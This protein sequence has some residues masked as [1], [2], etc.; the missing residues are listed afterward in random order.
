MSPEQALAQRVVVDH[1]TDV[2]SLGATLYELLALEPAFNGRDRRELLRQIAFEEP[3]RPRR[4]NRSIPRELEVIVLKAMERNPADRYATAQALADDLRRFLEDKPIRARP[5]TPWQRLWKWGRRHQAVVAAAFLVLLAA[6]GALAASSYFFWH[7]HGLTQH[8]LGKANAQRDR[9][10]KRLELTINALDRMSITVGPREA[11]RDPEMEKVRNALLDGARRAL[12][13][14]LPDDGPDQLAREEAGRLYLAIG[15]VYRRQREFARAEEAYG[16]T[17]AVYASL[18]TEFPDFV[19]Y[20]QYLDVSRKNLDQVRASS[21]IAAGQTP[22]GFPGPSGDQR[23]LGRRY[24]ELGDQLRKEPRATIGGVDERVFQNMPWFPI[25]GD[26]PGCRGWPWEAAAAYRQA[27]AVRRKLAAGSPRAKDHRDLLASCLALANLM[28]QLREKHEQATVLE[29]AAAVADQLAVEF[30]DAPLEWKWGP[31][32]EGTEEMTI[33]PPDE[34]Q[35]RDLRQRVDIHRRLG[36]V[37]A[38]AAEEWRQAGSGREAEAADR[39][40]EAAY[41]RAVELAGGR[42]VV[43]RSDT[44]AFGATV[45]GGILPGTVQL[46]AIGWFLESE[47]PNGGTSPEEGLR[48]AT[49][50]SGELVLCCSGLASLYEETGRPLKAERAYRQLLVVCEELAQ[51][52]LGQ[53]PSDGDCLRLGNCRVA[54]GRCLRSMGRHR[55]AAEEYIKAVEHYR[56]GLATVSARDSLTPLG[57]RLQGNVALYNDLAWLLATCPY[58]QARDPAQA[59][60][61]AKTAVAVSPTKDHWK[62]LGVAHYRA[63]HYS[64][65]VAALEK[66]V[67]LGNE[68]GGH[69][70]FILAMARWQLG[71]KAEARAWYAKA[72]S[73]MEKNKGSVK[74]DN[75]VNDE[76][77]RFG[78]EAAALLEIK[79]EPSGK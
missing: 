11:R 3:R 64:D 28:F 23:D 47:P 61:L 18:A 41:R 68:H 65:A 76:P 16:K 40:A 52:G 77:R 31:G 42:V 27:V 43:D 29:R 39:R 32:P 73:W 24:Q 37:S 6:I 34:R 50:F 67:Q 66:S 78:A 21:R 15:N 22:D 36:L 59:V 33:G 56:K 63:G 12:E 26:E 49:E 79:T 57:V 70:W 54:L 25:V 8:A 5:P 7:E 75:G 35:R 51:A 2:Y 44:L 62:T 48:P 17:V 69:D 1:R 55:E 14:S 38:A 58:P 60:E 4:R 46:A 72:V 53:R 71:D 30:P 9:A 10:Y 74:Q 19:S 45:A 20:P 13:E